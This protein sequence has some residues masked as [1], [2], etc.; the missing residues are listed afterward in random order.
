MSAL[1]I[2][3]VVVTHRRRGAPP[4]HAVKGVS[5][6]VERG[7]IVGLVG[8]SGCGKSSLARVAVGIDR[9]T[10]GAVR[11][12]GESL[13]P[14]T[15]RRR[16]R[17]DRGLQMVFQNPYASLSPRR[18]IGAQLLDGAPTALDRAAGA[19]EVARLLRLVGLDESAASRYPAQ[20][21]GGQRQRL[22]IARALAAKPSVVV[23]DEPVTALDAFSSAQIV[24]LLQDLVRDL[25]MAMLFISHDLSLVRAIAD[26]TAVMYAGEIIERGPS[27]QLWQNSQHPY[28]QRLIEAIP[29]IGTTKKLPGREEDLAG[30]GAVPTRGGEA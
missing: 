11:F 29:E 19:A 7:Q 22:A 23:A 20:F 10:S 26:E 15:M 28:T 3:D 9:P 8:E 4:V 1:E 27:E 25:G 5:L 16:P 24:E 13:H 12:E 14:L 17:R 2:E 30:T 6:T 18:S 21:S